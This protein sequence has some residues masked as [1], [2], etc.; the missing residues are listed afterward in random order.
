MTDFTVDEDVNAISQ[1]HD[2]RP[3]DRPSGSEERNRHP[4]QFVY[5]QSHY[6]PGM[7][8]FPA[9]ALGAVEQ[10]CD[11]ATILVGGF[12]EVGHPVGLIDGLLDHGA[13]DLTI[14]ANNAGQGEE[15]LARLMK[16]RR[17]KKAI[18]SFPRQKTAH[19]FEDAYREGTTELEV[20]PQGTLAERIRAGGAGIGGFYTPTAA[21][22]LLAEG[23]EH[24]T[25]NGRLQVL[26]L[27]IVGDF[28]F[29][30]AHRADRFGN[31]SYRKTARNFG[32]VMATAAA[33]T[34]V[35][36][37]AVVD[38]ALDP[39]RIVTPGIFTDIIWASDRRTE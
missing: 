27:P 33:T 5:R 3:D 28:A 4:S 23:K 18:C 26:E 20:V 8:K 10:I 15:G 22:T 7:K 39:E 38:S 1:G 25:L 21:G 36:A 13:R 30:S 6:F 24:R 37:D 29:V 35:E 19:H 32:H 16:E 17:V 34:I 14:V 31:L 12:G 9:D 11:G 2:F